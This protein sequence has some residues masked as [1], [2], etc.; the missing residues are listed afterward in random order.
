MYDFITISDKIKLDYKMKMLENFSYKNVVEIV[1]AL[2]SYY[3]NAEIK[4]KEI[5][6]L[7]NGVINESLNTKS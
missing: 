6:G 5:N 4:I 2:C 1:E 3:K 7:I